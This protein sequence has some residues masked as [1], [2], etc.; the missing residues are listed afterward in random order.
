MIL[1]DASVEE[2][3]PTKSSVCWILKA[4]ASIFAEPQI[5]VIFQNPQ[6]TTNAV[7]NIV[8]TALDHPVAKTVAYWIAYSTT[9]LTICRR[10][11]NVYSHASYS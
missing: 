10:F 8:T 6:N 7:T 11:N 9:I 4:S 3:I 1:P 5:V 2:I